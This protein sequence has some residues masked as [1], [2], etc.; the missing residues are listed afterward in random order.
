[1]VNGLSSTQL[2]GIQDAGMNI[3]LGTFNGADNDTADNAMLNNAKDYDIGFIIDKRNWNGTIPAYA[4]NNNF[5]GY[6]TY[7]EPDMSYLGTL[8]EM[9][10]K[11]DESE[12]KD[13]LFYINLNPCYTTRVND[14]EEY[15]R[16]YTEDVGLDMVSTDYYALYEDSLANCGVGLREDWLYDLSIS[17]YYAKK[18][19][20]PLWFTLLTTK[21]QASGLTYINPSAKDLEYQMYVAMAFGTQYL[22]HY[23]YS[24]TGSD[25]INPIIDK[26][27]QPTDSY[28]DVKE[29]SEAI[30]K[31]DEFYMDFNWVG[32]TGIYGNNSVN[33]LID[34]LFYDIPVN[35]TGAIKQA[36]SSQDVIIGHFEDAQ[37]NKGYLVTNLTNPYLEKTAK[38]TFKF[39]SKYKGVKVYQ[40]GKSTVSLL[41]DGKLDLSIKPGEGVF[42]I[43][44]LAK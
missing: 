36:S 17:A 25:H 20:V 21:H 43:P 11:W 30:R 37:N 19:N 5:L 6:C 15:I 22:I 41:D 24:A 2:K 34:Y 44:L 23:T 42:V 39:D 1:M 4:N 35:N 27:G 40:D 9:K 29:S 12:L 14:Y 26:K 38:T 31:W 16:A 33:S 18:N 8:T 32:A 10:R 13:K 3:M 7:D 28:Y